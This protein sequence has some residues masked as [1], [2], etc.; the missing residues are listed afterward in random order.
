M[1]R[2]SI[3]RVLCRD[4][5]A[6]LERQKI[7]SA[8]FNEVIGN[9]PSGLPCAEGVYRIQMASSEYSEARA[10]V[11][12]AMN[13]LNNFLIHGTVPPGLNGPRRAGY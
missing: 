13:R 7:A 4:L 1:D 9:S 11:L 6:A 3:I 5:A 2:E 10:A 8:H 12:D